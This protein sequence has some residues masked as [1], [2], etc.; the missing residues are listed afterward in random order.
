MGELRG[1]RESTDV[2]ARLG[3]VAATRRAAQERRTV[4][5][6]SMVVKVLPGLVLCIDK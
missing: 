3:A 4:L 2:P 6:Q 5:R 1:E